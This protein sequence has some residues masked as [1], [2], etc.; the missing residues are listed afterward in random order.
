MLSGIVAFW[1]ISS[2][3]GGITAATERVLELRPEMLAREG[4]IS[5]LSFFTY[6]LIPLSVGTVPHVFQHWLTARSAKTF[7]LTVV[8]HPLFILLVWVPCI[9][10]GVWATVAVLP[11]GSLVVPPGSRPNTELALMV[12]KLTSPLLGGLLGAGI[13]AAIMSSLDSQFLCLG[14]MF[15]TDIV[16]HYLGQERFDD[17]AR[18]LIARAFIVLIVAVTYLLSLAEPVHVFTLGVWCFSGFASLF[19]LVYAA[20]YWKRVTRAGAFAS[21]LATVAVWS[22]LFQASGYGADAGYEFLGMMPVATIFLAS[23]AALILVSLLTLP[24]SP[25][26]LQKYFPAGSATAA[27][28]AL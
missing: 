20:I 18:I 22:A 14:T 9:L 11:D 3:L 15:T 13:L 8:A 24:P 10:I 12:E 4:Q 2:K 16:T 17:R 23:T 1:I 28:Q 7:R 19:P 6:F 27:S 5:Q 25:Q 21:V 26:T